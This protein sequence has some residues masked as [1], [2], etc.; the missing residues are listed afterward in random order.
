MKKNKKTQ[1]TRTI[2]KTVYKPKKRTLSERFE[3]AKDKAEEVFE[4]DDVQGA[5]CWGSMVFGGL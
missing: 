2:K 4:R 5:I 1:I 3:D